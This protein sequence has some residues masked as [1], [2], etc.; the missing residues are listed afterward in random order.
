MTERTSTSAIY[1]QV[2]EEVA[3][4]VKMEFTNEGLS[5]EVRL[6]LKQL[7][8]AKLAQADIAPVPTAPLASAEESGNLYHLYHQDSSAL[9]HEGASF[10]LSQSNAGRGSQTYGQLVGQYPLP[11]PQEPQYGRPQPFLPPPYDWNTNATIAAPRQTP[12]AGTATRVRQAANANIPQYDGG[13]DE[14]ELEGDANLGQVKKENM[15]DEDLGSDLDD[16]DEDVE[17]ETSNIVICQFE[18]VSRVKNKRKCALKA[19]VMH[20]NGRDY[21]FN[22]ANGEFHW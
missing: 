12:S 5:D 1:A 9:P 10:L 19:G 14:D 8:E 16:E 22:R 3:S 11:Q 4:N 7:W 2:I 17:P 18:K 13:D 21:L 6:E 15:G 20:L